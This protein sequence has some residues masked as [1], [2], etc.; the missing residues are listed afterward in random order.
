MDILFIKII[1][2]SVNV[3]ESIIAV[4]FVTKMSETKYSGRKQYI[5]F[6]IAFLLLMINAEIFYYLPAFPDI[7]AYFTLI[8]LFI[9][10]V[11]ALKG[12]IFYR[13]FSC[14]MIMIVTIGVNF[15]TSL[16]FGIIFNVRIEELM[17]EFS[18]YR[19][20]CLIVSKIIL[21]VVT[22][23][24]VRMK[25]KGI[26]NINP[27]TITSFTAVPIITIAV[28]VV[29]TE[30]SIELELNDRNTFYLLL[31]FV[32]MIVINIVFYTLLAKLDREYNLKIENRLLKQ[33]NS[34]QLEY[35]K[36]TNALNEEI[37]AIRHDMKNRIIYLKEIFLKG[38]YEEGIS[39]ADNMIEKI[40]SMYKLIY[41]ERFA[42]DA[43]VNT[44]L[45]EAGDKNISVSYNIMCS[46][47]NNIE[48]DDLVSLIGNI[49]DNAIEACEYVQGR[50]EI[51]LEAKKAHS[52][53]L[54]TIK[55]T[56]S[57]SVLKNNPQLKST[58]N[59]VINHGLGIKNVKKIVEK[60]NGF[61]IYEEESDEFICKV[62][63]LI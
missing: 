2:F 59:D 25:T 41:T 32:G 10:S 42:F 14:V 58:K 31:S 22:R 63:L 54:I 45:M 21:F 7:M 13:F 34:L 29:I 15:L 11:I 24:L 8:I 28:M 53:L 47:D 30:V 17:T 52:Y 60:Y 19:F 1:E 12:K 48:D 4:E 33:K 39:Y 37:R 43:V 50:K 51:Y 35:V 23:I 40:D 55:N 9:Y 18:T 3:F 44:K 27:I 38:S 36:N 56:V 16:I 20:A 62:M 57:E 61:V 49:F 26:S 5:A 6:G 46:L